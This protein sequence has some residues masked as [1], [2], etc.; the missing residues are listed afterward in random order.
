MPRPKKG[1]KTPGSGIK[2]GYK[3]ANTLARERAKQAVERAIYERCVP[4]TLAQMDEAMGIDYLVIRRP[5]GSF[6]RATDQAQIDAGLPRADASRLR[7]AA[8][9][10]PD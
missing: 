7:Q 5:D 4:L 2:K 9:S 8:Q 3:Y 1:E 6:V 10:A